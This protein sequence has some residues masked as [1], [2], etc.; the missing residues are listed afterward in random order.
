MSKELHREVPNHTVGAG[1]G[2]RERGRG[3]GV[4]PEEVIHHLIE[5]EAKSAR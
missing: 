2:R 3:S 4:F 5:R 1:V